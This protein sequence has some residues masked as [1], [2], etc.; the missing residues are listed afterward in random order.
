MNFRSKFGGLPA[1]A[2]RRPLLILVLNLLIIIA[3]LGAYFGLEIRELPDVD[4]PQV[5]INASFPGAAPETMDT[6]VTR[7]LE[8][9]A[10]RVSGVRTISS[11][12]EEAS[13]RIVIEFQAGTDLD[14][15]AVEVREAV[16][17]IERDLP[18]DVDRVVV[19]KADSDARGMFTFTVASDTLD[20][21]SL[22]ELVETDLSPLF[23]NIP[24]VADVQS[25]G[26]RE[27]VARVVV[28]PLRLSDYNLSISAVADRLRDAPFDIPAGSLRSSDQELLVRADATTTT[29]AQLGALVLDDNLYLDDVADIYFGPADA[30]N[31]VRMDDEPVIS[32]TI[33]RQAGANTIAISNA[34][35]EALE[36]ARQRFPEL[37]LQRVTDDAQFIRDSVQQVLT[38]LIFT[39]VL[40][41]LT[42]RLFTGS[43]QATIVPAVAI[44]VALVGALA[45][46]WL[47]GFSLN[48]LTLLA[49]VLATGLIVDDAIVVTENIHRHRAAGLGA[50]AAAVIGTRE[51]FFAV[52]ATTAV[53]VSVFVP[54]AFLPS[55]AGRLF[56][57]FGG[58]LAATVIISSFVALSIV[59]ALTARL[60]L[61]KRR[62]RGLA[63]RLGWSLKSGYQ[64][65]LHTLL[66]RPLWSLVGF[67]LLAGIA[68][69][70]YTSLDQELLPEED[71]GVIR[72]FA[73][74]PDGVGLPF[75]DRQA[76]RAED[77]FR[78]LR[79]NGLAT[80]V[81][82]VVGQWDPNL[83]AMTIPLVHWRERDESL[84]DI[85]GQL[86]AD[87]GDIPGAPARAF[88][89]N[90]LNLRG[91][92]GGL[93]FA[94]T[95]REYD[96]IYT[97]AQ[98]F[99]ALLDEHLP[100]LTN[101]Q[102]S[103]QPTQ[104]ELQ[105]AI[106]RSRA[107]ELGVPLADV[108]QALRVAINGD[109]LGDLNVADQSVPIMLQASR[110]QVREPEDLQNIYLE[111]AN[112]R[113]VPLTSV[114]R[115]NEAGIAAEL[116][117]RAQRRAIEIDTGLADDAVLA[118]VVNELQNLAQEHL[119]AD[120]GLVLLGEAL[121]FMETSRDVN[122]TYIL[123]LLIV[124][125]VLI[126]QFENLNSAIVVMVTV[127]FGLAAAV[128]AL[129]L[130]GQSLNI[131]SQIGLVM[132]IGL[133][134]K[135]A[136]LLVE[137]ADQ[138]RD[139]GQTVPVAISRAASIRLRPISMTLLSTILGTL[140]L[141]LATG[142]GAEA[143]QAIG[144]VVF[145]GLGITALLTLYL[146]P[147][148]YLLLAR[149]TKPRAAEGEQLEEE[150]AAASR[151]NPT[152]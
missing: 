3:G 100:A 19:I 75:M 146:T 42:L 45:A 91:Q 96:E 110:L 10:A 24:G 73:R 122:L 124:F 121:T 104:P 137:F 131:Y 63:Q 148:V 150:L 119:P 47:L 86:R 56:R 123:A 142:A 16:S 79:E 18:D 126:A 109:D 70:V 34:A 7:R 2:I 111:S 112:G 136:V 125:L 101:P 12:S 14:A 99:I 39:I 81:F 77:Y 51:V 117:R 84:Q 27:R 74:G 1:L 103:Y 49:I 8:G 88:G 32:L 80:G 41:V 141:V 97:Q 30:Q 129:F 87:L 31:L 65:S 61:A 107:Q 38:T 11:S 25:R 115:F 17:Q 4:R 15:A 94:L 68:A 89:G 43:W 78:P 116:E 133:L 113:L 9:A 50:R 64:S 37:D 28:D 108:A 118:D 147:V 92:S 76:Q 130:S 46:L 6:E 26:N 85:L 90:S 36:Q 120:T 67:S 54:I 29:P 135:N 35:Q 20:I 60:P 40:V 66:R 13:T 33:I 127:P 138:L 143:R 114:A 22:T 95:G 98:D 48:I 59:P 55:T 139:R 149:F 69:T 57:E 144:W 102:I 72:V 132:L 93:E 105:V 23:L 83:N 62:T 152:K 44:P 21:E 128:F 71:R 140:P 53:L 52:I 134:A 82:T 58:I 145:G 151:Q 5:T 106:D